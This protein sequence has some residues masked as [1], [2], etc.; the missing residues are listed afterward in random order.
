MAQLKP[1]GSGPR[2]EPLDL[3]DELRECRLTGLQVSGVGSG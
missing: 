3:A 2:E 1:R